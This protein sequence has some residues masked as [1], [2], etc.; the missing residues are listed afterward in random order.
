MIYIAGDLAIGSGTMIPEPLS[1]WPSDDGEE[2]WR[3]HAYFDNH[4]LGPDYYPIP[5]PFANETDC[6]IAANALVQAGLTTA[7]AIIDCDKQELR[8]I[9]CQDLRW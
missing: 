4:R 9:L 1:S 2:A 8:R 7:Q 3:V 5:L 6:R